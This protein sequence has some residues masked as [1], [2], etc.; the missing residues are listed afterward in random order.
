M[1]IKFSGEKET[2]ESGATKEVKKGRG[3]PSLIFP[4]LITRLAKWLELGGKNHGDRNWEKGLPSDSYLDAL[5]RHVLAYH[6][7][8]R[9]EDHLAAMLFNVQGLIF[10]E[11]L[12]PD[13]INLPDHTKKADDCTNDEYVKSFLAQESGNTPAKPTLMVTS[14]GKGFDPVS[15]KP[16]DID[17][18]DIFKGLSN[19]CRFAGQLKGGIDFYSVAQHSVLAALWAENDGVPISSC[20]AILLHDFSEAYLSDI[21]SPV[22]QV[23]PEYRKLENGIMDAV[24]TKFM[25]DP[26]SDEAKELI[27]KYDH[28]KMLVQEIA[29]LM[30]PSEIFAP[31]IK[32]SNAVVPTF[33]HNGLRNPWG[34][35]KSYE[36]L[37]FL[38]NRYMRIVN[39]P[40]TDEPSELDG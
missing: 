39:G 34:I 28:C 15:P 5:Y 11:E 24:Y 23:L 4:C 16:E 33:V 14:T 1:E 18:K 12:R 13:L 8:D 10:N 6:F 36:E 22:K 3:K 26:I 20:F 40:G 29:Y 25:G 19:N 17:I 30:E 37:W 38:F 21:S 27:H 32:E 7:G 35:R 9:S 31:W 2:F